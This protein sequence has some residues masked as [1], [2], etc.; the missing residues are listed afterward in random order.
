M[1][2]YNLEGKQ[3][4]LTHGLILENEEKEELRCFIRILAG[5]TEGQ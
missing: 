5:A 2:G 3:M 4:E 1:D